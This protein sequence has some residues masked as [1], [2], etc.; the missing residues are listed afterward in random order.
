MQRPPIARTTTLI[1]VLAALA[2][3]VPAAG[4]E[5]ADESGG[6]LRL[7]T[8]QFPVSDDIRSNGEWIRS[9]MRQASDEGADL[10][11]FPE[12]ALSG[13]AGVDLSS[14]DG[15]DWDA[16]HSETEAILATARDLGVWV[17]LG[18]T[19][20]LGGDHRPHNSLYVI[21]PEGRIV[22]RYDKRFCTAGDL[23]HYSPGDH[24]VTFEVDGVRCGLLI[25]YDIRFPELYR[26]YSK[27]GV[28]LML[29]SFYNARQKPGSIHP[30]I[31]PV[32]ARAYA[33]VN[34][35]FVSINN[36]SA[37]RS[38]PSRFITPDGLVGASL[39]TDEPGV[40]VNVVD[41]HEPYY[42]ASGPFRPDA[43]RGKLNSGEA[44]DDPRSE[45]RTSH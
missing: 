35:M 38:W 30:E 21:N 6:V 28:R 20:R 29:H 27:L 37:P 12:C 40:M 34:N 44:V 33:G 5:D 16:L 3:C 22:D 9:Q 19:H 41:L 13:Y 45:D 15:L 23:E 24:F 25:C 26:E 10:I 11:H 2:S 31:M 42:D 8:C 1:A 14:I 7:A 4:A 43:L 39:P 36:S 17:V 18:S 32:T